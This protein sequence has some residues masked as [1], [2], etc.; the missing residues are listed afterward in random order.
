[1]FSD[2]TNIDKV[3]DKV[4]QN[5]KFLCKLIGCET[6]EG[7][8]WAR[9]FFLKENIVCIYI[10]FKFQIIAPGNPYVI[11]IRDTESVKVGDVFSHRSQY[12]NILSLKFLFFF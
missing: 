1:M 12:V 3:C 8:E 5:I 4:G 7:V 10:I 2:I 11:G 6:Q 9:K